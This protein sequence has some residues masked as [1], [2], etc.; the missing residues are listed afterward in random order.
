MHLATDSNFLFVPRAFKASQSADKTSFIQCVRFRDVHGFQ[1]SS[2]TPPVFN[3]IRI[4]R[5]FQIVTLFAQTCISGAAFWHVRPLTRPYFLRSGQVHFALGRS[6]SSQFNFTFQLW[7]NSDR[8]NLESS[9]HERDG[10]VIVHVGRV[11]FFGNGN[12]L[13][14]RSVVTALPAVPFFSCAIP[15]KG[16]MTDVNNYRAISLMNTTLKILTGILT[17]RINAEYEIENLFNPAQAGCRRIEECVTHTGCLQEV[18][19]RR[20]IKRK[21]THLLFIDLHKAYDTVPHEG[22][23]TKLDFYGVKGDERKH[24]FVNYMTTAPSPSE[25]L[26][27][28]LNFYPESAS[29]ISLTA[30]NAWESPFRGLITAHKCQDLSPHHP[31]GQI[32]LDWRRSYILGGEYKRRQLEG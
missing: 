2:C 16:D 17:N 5:T 22:P 26:P 28:P 8:Q 13:G 14:G 27:T 1:T 30:W 32:K 3:L 15:K 6:Y 23:F 9:V 18:D 10:A 19:R 25:D 21:E 12:H 24:F 7:F 31:R 4:C 20:K 29:T 11:S